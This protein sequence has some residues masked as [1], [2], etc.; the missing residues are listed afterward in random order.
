MDVWGGERE[1]WGDR[2]WEMFT[3][4]YIGHRRMYIHRG[5]HA[6]PKGGAIKQVGSKSMAVSC[7]GILRSVGGE[8]SSECYSNISGRLGRCAALAE[9]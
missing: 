4:L 3:G 2:P 8:K 6:R 1:P 5:F 7:T 9:G